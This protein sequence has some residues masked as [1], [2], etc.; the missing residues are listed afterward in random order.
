MKFRIAAGAALL[1][2]IAAAVQR[3]DREGTEARPLPS[4]VPGGPAGPREPEVRGTAPERPARELETRERTSATVEGQAPPAEEAF[5]PLPRRRRVPPP[6]WKALI[7]RLD[8]DLSLREEQRGM[9][10]RIL[11]ERDREIRDRHDSIRAAQ[12]LN[13]VEYEWWAA[14]RKADWYRQ[15][16]GLLDASQHERFLALVG[17]GLFNEGLAFTVEPGMTVLE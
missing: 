3:A 5:P 2:G 15:I 7:G 14:E 4:V 8:R 13:L 16:D 10:E 12:V 9:V 11:K 17:K 6:G 1:L